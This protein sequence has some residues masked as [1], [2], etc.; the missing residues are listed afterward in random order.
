MLMKFYRLCLHAVLSEHWSVSHNSELRNDW[1]QW[2][3]CPYRGVSV[4]LAV[5][6]KRGE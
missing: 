4:T 2:G 1:R 5:S 3:C 6:K